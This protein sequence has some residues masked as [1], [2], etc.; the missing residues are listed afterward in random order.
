MRGEEQWLLTN[1]PDLWTRG[2]AGN[3]WRR[4][5]AKVPGM[6]AFTLHDLRHFYA[7]ALIAAGCDVVTVQRALGHS[8]ASITLDVYSHLWST[9]EERTREA[10]TGLMR[11]V[12]GAPADPVRTE[13]L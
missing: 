10:A 9:G 13:G 1:G 4:V 12:L 11:T 8:S 6:E 7:S 2:A 3:V 5:R